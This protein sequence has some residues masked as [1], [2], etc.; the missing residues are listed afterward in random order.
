MFSCLSA[1]AYP[2]LA[3]V[4]EPITIQDE[5]TGLVSKQ[6][7]FK[8]RIACSAKNQVAGGIDKNAANLSSGQKTIK[9]TEVLKIRSKLL[10]ST[11][12]R[13]VKIRNDR[14]VIWLEGDIINTEGGFE[15]STIFEPKGSVPI[16]DHNGTVIEWETTISRQDIQKLE[17]YVPPPPEEGP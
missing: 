16:L 4:Y 7:V 14:G 5:D 13:V 2:L 1:N 12:H 17:I 9:A 8:E 11:N 15:G 10:V 3:D 6:W